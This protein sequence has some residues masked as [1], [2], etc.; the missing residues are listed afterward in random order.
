[1]GRRGR[2]GRAGQYSANI[3]GDLSAFHLRGPL[4]VEVGRIIEVYGKAELRQSGEP[5]GQ[6][7][8]GIVFAR[9]GAVAALVLH[10][11]LVSKRHFLAGLNAVADR[12]AVFETD[13]AALIQSEF[14]VDQVAVILQ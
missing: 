2:I 6:T 1:G 12:F 4:E 7:I 9:D 10:V 3:G 8:D 5:L 14:G 13:P 11:E